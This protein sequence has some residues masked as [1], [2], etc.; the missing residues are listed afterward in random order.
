MIPSA[1]QKCHIGF[2]VWVYLTFLSLREYE[3]ESI[4]RISDVTFSAAF[5]VA[6]R[7][8][9]STAIESLQVRQKSSDR[10]SDDTLSDAFGVANRVEENTTINLGAQYTCGFGVLQIFGKV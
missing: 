9:E 6:N 3:G 10:I 8:E 1:H 2:I 7:D 4:G 5:G